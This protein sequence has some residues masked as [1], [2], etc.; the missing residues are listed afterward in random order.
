MKRIGFLGA[1]SIDNTGDQVLGYAVRQVFRER[2]PDAEQVV[3]SPALRGDF[4]RHAW[5]VERGIDVEVRKIPADDSTTWAR[6]LDAVV[7]GGGGLIRLEPDFR[8]FLLGE[9][10][11]WDPSIPAAWN[12][13]GAENA[14]PQMP[15][16]RPTYRAVKRCCE[17][18]AYVSVRNDTTARFVRQCGFSG[19]LPVVPD[20]TMLLSLPVDEDRGEAILRDAG[21]DTGRFVVGLS[22]GSSIRDGRAVTFY[23]ELFAALA[24]RANVTEI[25]LFPFG[26]VYGDTELQRLAHRALPG[27]KLIEAKL[28]ALD[29]WRLIG[30]LDLHVCT[31]YHAMLAAF[32]QDTPFV[33]L[34][35]YLSDVSCSSKIRDFVVASDLEAFYLCPY[36]STQPRQKL[37]TAIAISQDS[38]FSFLRRVQAFQKEL[39]VHYDTMV[40]ALGLG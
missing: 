24:S 32:A 39:G 35:E 12:A 5:T 8:P 7:I 29:R 13:V 30:A 11:D 40:S 1:Y 27:A 25:V 34:D 31:R 14:P 15:D 23:K 26:N 33:V 2:V 9:A 4:W 10:S 36:L 17:A 37:S 38:E 18:L 3:L 6:G 28:T 19:A 22:V 16:Q 20:P 21:V